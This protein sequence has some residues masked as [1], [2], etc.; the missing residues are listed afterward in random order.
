MVSTPEM[1]AAHYQLGCYVTDTVCTGEIKQPQKIQD[2]VVHRVF[3]NREN[4]LLNQ[5]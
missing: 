2:L 4:S 1:V 3:P 5:M